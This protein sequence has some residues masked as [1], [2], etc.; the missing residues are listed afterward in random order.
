MHDPL[1]A[2]IGKSIIAAAVLGIPA[3]LLKIPL[4]LAFLIAGVSLG[5]NLG[6]GLIKDATSISTLSEMG[7]VLLMFI[8]GQ[9]V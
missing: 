1:M 9:I 7:L 6:L 5:P 4:L 8:L 3:H 2:D